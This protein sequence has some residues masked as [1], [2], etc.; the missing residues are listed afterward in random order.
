MEEN[1]LHVPEGWD[2]EEFG[3]LI[4]EKTKSKL[5]V[6]DATNFGGFPFFTSGDA[7]LE[8]NTKQVEGEN[9]FLAT[10]GVA[11][12]KYFDGEVSYSTDTFTISANNKI[13]TKFLYFS[14]LDMIKYI[15]INYFQGSGLK[16]LQKKDL[17]NHTIIFPKSSTEQQK[18]ASILS[19][20]DQ[21]IAQTEAL[22]D[23]YNRI[24][25]GLMQDLLT[26]GIDKNGNIRSEETHEFKDSELG[27]IP[28]EWKV[29]K[30]GNIISKGN[31]WIQ[32]GPFGSQLHANEYVEEGTPVIMPQNII[33]SRIDISDIAKIKQEKVNQ[34]KRHIVEIGD[35]VFARRG[36]LSKCSVIKHENA[37]WICGT[38]CLLIRT[39]QR[40]INSEWL[41]IIYQHE[42]CQIQVDINATGSTMQNLNTK[43]LSDLLIFDI[44][45]NEQD[46]IIEYINK[47]SIIIDRHVISLSKLQSL[48]TGI[49]H[50]LLSGKVR[51]NQLIT[52]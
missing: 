32:T 49:M 31:G 29:E 21:A 36:D 27:R 18:I 48:K 47:Q 35:I 34:M 26:K 45:K 1:Q 17:R 51:V 13:E 16:H 11:N 23:K 2:I 15:N 4:S 38:G 24:K 46:K 37:G 44:A 30:L 19:K 9:I 50:D 8:H 7:I 6:S 52:N 10:G 12:V 28:K 39:P 42:F 33:K 25:T 41:S 3:N 20:T 40:L 43:I 22:I 14:L 5:K